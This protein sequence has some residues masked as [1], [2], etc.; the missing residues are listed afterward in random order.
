MKCWTCGGQ[1]LDS[2]RVCCCGD[3]GPHSDEVDYLRKRA[4]RADELE[5][6]IGL[7]K[8]LRMRERV[9]RLLKET[10]FLER[11]KIV[12]QYVLQKSI[13]QKQWVELPPYLTAGR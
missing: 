9:M 3:T 4:Q 7:P 1:P 6:E 8:D 5:A 10:S 11:Q 12:W 2:G 13:S